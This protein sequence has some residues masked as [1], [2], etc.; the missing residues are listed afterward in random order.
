[1]SHMGSRIQSLEANLQDCRHKLHE[2]LI[3]LGSNGEGLKAETLAMKCHCERINSE[4]KEVCQMALNSM[5]SVLRKNGLNAKSLVERVGERA[6]AAMR[7]A[8]EA[9]DFLANERQD[10]R[11]AVAS[12]GDLED[13]M[14]NFYQHQSEPYR[15][16][17]F[18]TQE[19]GEGT[20][21][22]RL[23]GVQSL[24]ISCASG[25]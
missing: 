9:K 3:A 1:M 5:N 2:V 4:T 11:V 6:D 10:I 19:A 12:F 21:E 18:S 7:L 13:R 15:K 20:R 23:R 8:Q 17:G 22:L 14:T 24:S 25:C 16:Y